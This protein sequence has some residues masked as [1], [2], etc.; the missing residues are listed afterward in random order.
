MEYE[1]ESPGF[2]FL[3]EISINGKL[4]EETRSLGFNQLCC[5]NPIRNL[6]WKLQL[7]IAIDGN[8]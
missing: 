7:V 1:N 4:E 3:R 8:S 2:Q 5:Y 6:N